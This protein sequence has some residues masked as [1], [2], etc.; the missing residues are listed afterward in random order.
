LRSDGRFR[1]GKSKNETRNTKE[2]IMK[3]DVRCFATLANEDT[4]DY[5][6]A[7]TY[8]LDEGQTVGNLA[9]AAGVDAGKVKITFVNGRIRDFNTELAHGDRVGFVPA[10]GGM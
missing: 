5:R 9:E 7:S 1:N 6:S 10:V 4:C 8:D 3:V 2:F